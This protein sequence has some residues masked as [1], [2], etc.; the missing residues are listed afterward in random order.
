M[1]KNR[2]FDMAESLSFSSTVI[3]PEGGNVTEISIS[4][5]QTFKAHPF[6]VTDDEKMDELAKSI[7]NSGI[8]VPVL[9]RPSGAGKYEIISG[10]RRTYAAVKAGLDKVPCIIKNLSDDDATVVMVDSNIQREN[11]LP[12]ERAFAFKMKYEALKHQGKADDSE[13]SSADRIGEDAGESGR[14]VRRYIK[15]TELN[16]LLLGL[17]DSGVISMA[18]GVELAGL[19]NADQEILYRQMDILAKFG[20]D[21]AGMGI[22]VMQA[23]QIKDASAEGKLSPAVIKTILSGEPEKSAGKLSIPAKKVKEYF[24]ESYSKEQIEEVIYGL[25]E[26]WRSKQKDV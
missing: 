7:E 23:K 8:L 10:H 11:I 25:L 17:V 14:Q 18:A 2:K 4:D 15:L 5:L 13:G 3:Q 22:S 6:K 20:G 19:D 16:G 9:V 12:S 24:P 26:D 1:A 21:R